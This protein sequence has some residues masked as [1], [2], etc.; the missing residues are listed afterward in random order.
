MHKFIG[1]WILQEWHLIKNGQS[2]EYPMGIRAKG[3]LMYTEEG[4]MSATLMHENRKKFDKKTKADT[5]KL[6]ACNTFIA[7]AGDFEVR[8]D[9]IV[10]HVQTSLIPNWVGTE[11]VRNYK[12]QK[13]K[14][15]MTLSTEMNVDK[16]GTITQHVLIW[17]RR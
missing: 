14:Q 12:F 10:H 13:D 15:K 7:Y 9:K 8:G 1:S 6:N 2:K 3:T 4:M 11:L 5:V 17:K 16:D